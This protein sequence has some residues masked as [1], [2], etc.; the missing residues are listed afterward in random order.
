[1]WN[2]WEI[3]GNCTVV[4]KK[5]LL[6][7]PPFG[8]LGWLAGLIFIDRNNPKRANE[9][10]RSKYRLI[11]EKGVSRRISYNYYCA[12]FISYFNTFI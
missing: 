5:E 4:A 2:I 1:M 9:Q 10:I 12:I 6:F 7:V 3:M 11:S 8:Q